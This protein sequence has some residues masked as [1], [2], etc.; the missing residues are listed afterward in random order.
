[1]IDKSKSR[2]PIVS[3]HDLLSRGVVRP[4]IG[5]ARVQDVL[6]GLDFSGSMHGEPIAAALDGAKALVSELAKPENRGAFRVGLLLFNHDAHLRLPFQ[7]AT[8]PFEPSGVI[9]NGGTDFTK[10]LQLAHATLLPHGAPASD[11][12]R[13]SFVLLTDGRDGGGGNPAALAAEIRS[14]ANV[15]CIALGPDADLGFLTLLA[16]GPTFVTRATTGPELRA[17]F[18]AIGGTMSKSLRAGRSMA[19]AA[20]DPFASRRRA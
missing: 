6:L 10:A 17:Y 19:A 7:P 3:K 14:L 18:A 16:S 13:P 5:T 15:I 9:A 4:T 20:L 11:P 12:D 8:S 2:I 1:M